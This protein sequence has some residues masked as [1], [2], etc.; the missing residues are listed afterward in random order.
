MVGRCKDC[1]KV[2]WVPARSDWEAEV[3]REGGGGLL[4]SDGRG[5]EGRTEGGT[6]ARPG[7]THDKQACRGRRRAAPWVGPSSTSVGSGRRCTGTGGSYVRARRASSC[8]WAAAGGPVARQGLSRA[9]LRHPPSDGLLACACSRHC[10]QQERGH[11]T[12][13]Q[14]IQNIEVYIESSSRHLLHPLAPQLYSTVF[15]AAFPLP[16]DS[17]SGT[18]PSASILSSALTSSTEPARAIASRIFCFSSSPISRPAFF[19]TSPADDA[20]GAATTGEDSRIE[21]ARAVG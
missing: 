14:S 5:E 4:T 6:A 13:S 20:A 18:N 2:G 19:V 1:V 21:S 16:V 17:F 7:V 12:S 3:G 9:G 10:T 15:A 11:E 8:S